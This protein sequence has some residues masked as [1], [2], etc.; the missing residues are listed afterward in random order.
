MRVLILLI[1]ICS[2]NFIYAQKEID[3]LLVVLEKTMENRKGYDSQKELHIRNLKDL[4]DDESLSLE[5]IYQINNNI[6]SE[7]ETYSFDATLSYIEQN[8]SIANKLKNQLFIDESRLNLAKLL[9]S[10]GRDKEA[11]DI[12]TDIDREHLADKLLNRYYSNYKKV[13]LDLSFYSLANE[14]KQKYSNYYKVYTDSLFNR[15]DPSTEEYLAIVETKFRDN[16]QILESLKINTRRLAMTNIGTRTYSLASFERSLSYELELNKDE[17][18]KYLILSAIS[19]IQAA[20]K[21][22]ASLT[23]LALLLFEE[24]KIDRAHKYINF[25]FEDAEFYNSR[26]RFILI[27]NILPVITKAYQERSEMQRV[28]LQNLL[29]AI[30]ILGVV[31]LFTVF[32]IFKQVRHLST[33]RNELIQANEQFKE[34]NL[35]LNNTNS[36]LEKLNEDL[37]ESSL[38]KEH[39]IGTFLS[40]QSNYIDK[41]DAYRSMVKRHIITKKVADLFEKT[42]S[43]QLIDDELKLFYKNFDDTFLHIY[44]N[45]V[46]KLNNLLIEEGKIIPKNKGFLNTELRIFALIRLGITDSSIIAKLLRYSVNTIYNYRVKVKNN[47]AVPRD[48]FEDE[49]MKIGA[50]IK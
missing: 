42:K 5:Q 43:K 12:L 8:I 27:S 36:K 34:L 39:Y 50:S 28:K 22:N 9:A 44:P 31:L 48:N 2:C 7:Y 40:I 11:Y 6:I 3:S 21:D 26:L 46:E 15:L 16:R 49:V 41:L 1:F 10:S 32:F 29:I 4:L 35:K 24:N 33:T 19:D 14:N 25:S 18:K 37:S 38:V 17:Q 47:C 30:S 45:F 20:V 13:Y 23:T